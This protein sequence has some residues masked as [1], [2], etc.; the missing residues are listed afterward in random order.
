MRSVLILTLLTTISLF[1][2]GQKDGDEQ[3]T[4][5]APPA[6]ADAM[7]DAKELFSATMVEQIDMPLEDH[8]RLIAYVL[9]LSATWSN[10]ET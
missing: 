7:A 4:D 1:G 9:G 3:T 2:C 8:D 6:I 5:L 10:T